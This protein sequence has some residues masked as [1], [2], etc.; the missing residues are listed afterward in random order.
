M[1]DTDRQYP[2]IE[3]ATNHAQNSEPINKLNANL[4]F[5]CES[6]HIVMVCRQNFPISNGD[7]HSEDF[8]L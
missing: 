3:V 5:E 6:N 4:I 1:L 2:L 7:E 8:V